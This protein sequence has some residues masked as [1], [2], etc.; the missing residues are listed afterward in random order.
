[1]LPHSLKRLLRKYN[2]VLLGKVAR[3]GD[4]GA[5]RFAVD[6]CGSIICFNCRCVG[7]RLLGDDCWDW[8]ATDRVATLGCLW[9]GLSILGPVAAVA[10]VAA[11]AAVVAAV[12]AVA[13]GRCSAPVAA[14]DV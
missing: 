3:V 6:L 1:M 5:K 14:S 12:V 10:V 11:A 9:R 8:L 2:C 7:I 4:I 13:A